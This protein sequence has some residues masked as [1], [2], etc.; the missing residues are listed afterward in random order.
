MEDDGSQ[1]KGNRKCRGVYMIRTE[2]IV[3][4]ENI[5]WHGGRGDF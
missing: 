4:A 1:I 5:Q 2:A 3:T